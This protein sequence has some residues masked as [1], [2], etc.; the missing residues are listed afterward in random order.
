[1][2]KLYLA[3]VKAHVEAAWVPEGVGRAPPTAALTLPRSRPLNM[4][5]TSYP[6]PGLL[7]SCSPS[8]EC[9]PPGALPG[10]LLILINCCLFHEAFLGLIR[11]PYLV[12]ETPWRFDPSSLIT[13][14]LVH[15]QPVYLE[16][17]AQARGPLPTHLAGP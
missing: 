17:R 10:K 16:D 8:L 4:P 1:M 9:S 7:F 11:N 12:L 5:C 3:D 6:P 14:C 15:L 2:V 13:S